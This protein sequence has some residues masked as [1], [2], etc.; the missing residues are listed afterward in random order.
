MVYTAFYINFK[1]VTLVSEF[2]EKNIIYIPLNLTFIWEY[3]L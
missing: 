2:I 3:L 1:L